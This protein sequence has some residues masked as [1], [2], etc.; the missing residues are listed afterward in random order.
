MSL[1]AAARPA[2]A[3]EGQP[4]LDNLAH[5]PSVEVLEPRG[6][7]AAA[8]SRAIAGRAP[9]PDAAFAGAVWSA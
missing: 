9:R 7:S 4:V 1:V 2:E 8:V 3:G 5:N 6:L